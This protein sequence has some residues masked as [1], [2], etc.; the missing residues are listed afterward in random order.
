MTRAQIDLKNQ[1]VQASSDLT[2]CPLF[3]DS[4]VLFIDTSEQTPSTPPEQMEQV[5]IEHDTSKVPTPVDDTDRTHATL[6]PPKKRYEILKDP[7]FLSSPVYPPFVPSKPSLSK[8]MTKINTFSHLSPIK[9][10]VHTNIGLTMVSRYFHSSS[11]FFAHQSND[12][13]TDKSD[14]SFFSTSQKVAHH[15]T[16]T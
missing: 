9:E 2:K 15:Q 5:K 11:T 4:P 13:K 7:V 8:V 16:Y 14:P 10:W 12:I 3:N 6:P 1:L